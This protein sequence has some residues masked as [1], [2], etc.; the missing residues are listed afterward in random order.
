M[1]PWQ[2]IW[3]DI[4]RFF[5]RRRLLVV[6]EETARSLDRL[7][8]IQQLSTDEVLGELLETAIRGNEMDTYAMQ[9]W[10]ILSGQEKRVTALICAGMKTEQ[11]A[12]RLGI[13]PTTVK[14][15]IK[16]I[17]VKYQVHDRQV[18]REMLRGYDLKDFE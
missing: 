14:T 9:R 15:H 2:I 13:A 18:L 16:N 7:T 17:F 3:R 12:E 8:E 4:Q 6:K 5:H 10:Q 1:Y 11:I